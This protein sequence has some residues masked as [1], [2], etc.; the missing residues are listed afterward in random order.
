[1]KQYHLY[2]I[3]L[4]F[5]L[6]IGYSQEQLEKKRWQGKINAKSII[7]NNQYGDVRL[8]YGGDEDVVEYV[9]MIQHLDD[10]ESL[11][12]KTNETKNV[13]YIST[14]KEQRNNNDNKKPMGKTRVDITVFVPKNKTVKVQTNT[15]KVDSKGLKSNL[16]IRTESGNIKVRKHHGLLNTTTNTGNADIVLIKNDYAQP[17]K[18]ESIYG[19]IYVSVSDKSNIHASI[20]SSSNIIS[21]FSLKMTKHQN[22]EP[23]KTAEIKINKAN[24]KIVLTTKRGD[25]ALKEHRKF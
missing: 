23:N 22:S 3:A 14:D 15:G 19:N 5:N 2:L 7:V 1:M 25:L 9:A 17:Q 16:T 24:S 20:S 6:S 12:L 8:R 10:G 13:F 4:I 18:F 11:S 21:D